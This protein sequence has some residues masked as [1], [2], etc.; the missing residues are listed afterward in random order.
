MKAR[1]DT[2]VLSML[3]RDLKIIFVKRLLEES[4]F[5]FTDEKEKGI[6]VEG[7]AVLRIK[8]LKTLALKRLL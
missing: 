7:K 6:L 1:R 5:L 2:A 8:M 4:I 3:S